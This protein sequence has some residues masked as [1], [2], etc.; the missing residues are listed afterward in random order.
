MFNLI[1][2]KQDFG[3]EA[4]WT[5]T[6][7]AHGKGPGDGLGAS[8]K[9]TATRHIISSNISI[10]SAEDFYEFT[11]KFNDDA[12]NM[13]TNNQPPIHTFFI[14]STTVENVYNEVLKPRWDKLNRTGKNINKKHL[15]KVFF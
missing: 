15:E 11:R 12:A 14:K 1:Y 10:S 8:V 7:T 13:S 6:S 3:L 9:S 5:F 4:C 2:H